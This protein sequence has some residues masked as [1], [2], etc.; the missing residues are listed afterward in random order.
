[1]LRV[2][3]GKAILSEGSALPDGEY[4]TITEFAVVHGVG[5]PT[6]RAWKRRGQIDFVELNG[7]LYIPITSPIR[8]RG[9]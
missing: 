5:E 8:V 3:N 2:K 9:K 4:C 1:M 6:V 7:R